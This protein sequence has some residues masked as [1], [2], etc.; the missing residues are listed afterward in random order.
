M[1]LKCERLDHFGKGICY[2][3]GKIVF[4]KNLLPEEE[5]EI[6]IIVNKKNYSEGKII[7]LTKQSPNRIIPKCPYENCGCNLKHLKYEKQ[8]IFKEEKVKDIIK[9]YTK[10][11][12]KI[13]H[14]VPCPKQ[15]NYRNKITLKSN[16]KLGYHKEKSNDI[17]SIT[18]CELVS[19]NV[20]KIITI[21]NTL[22]LSKV[23][24]IVMKEF[25]E[26]MLSITGTIDIEPLKN[27]VNSIYVN[28]K[29][30]HGN[31]FIETN[32]LET[33]FKILPNSFFQVNKHMISKLYEIVLNYAGKN[34]NQK[35]LDLYCGTGTMT[36]L[37]SKYFKEVTGIEINEESIKCANINKE[38]NNIKNVKFICEDASKLKDLKADIIIVDPPRSGLTNEGIKDI[39][40][41]NPTKIIYV[42][43]D[44]MT[45]ARDLKT[46][47]EKYE[48]KE[49]TPVDMFPNTYH[50]ECV[51]LLE[52]C[53]VLIK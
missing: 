29:L 16:G 27:I 42:S 40:N 23:K 6:K 7:N 43:C 32:I 47:N 26:I 11:N 39:L 24:E 34:K 4:V 52:R 36:L 18:K 8:L 21:L 19:S 44:P 22:D 48:I 2:H 46:L 25:D 53:L 5:A 33:K 17:I 28:N 35:V 31:E 30:V 20:N 12:T 10:T 41:I 38:L 15:N 3:N 45:L 37:L 1:N 14:I 49:I 51:C 50:V 9:R 13:N